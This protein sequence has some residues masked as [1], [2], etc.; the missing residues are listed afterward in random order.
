MEFSDTRNTW[1]PQVGSAEMS[2]LV[3]MVLSRRSEAVPKQSFYGSATRVDGRPRLGA[4]VGLAM[5]GLFVW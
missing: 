2:S 5:E 4:I 3:Q 1:F